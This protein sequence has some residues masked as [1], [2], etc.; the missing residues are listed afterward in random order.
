MRA[1]LWMLLLA[2][3]G[4]GAADFRSVGEPG[5]I[6]YDA[7]AVKGKKLFV[8]S[9]DYPVEV[10]LTNDAWAR[11]RDASG[12]LAWVERKALSERRTVVVTAPVA[13][14]RNGPTDQS[15]VA[16]RVEKGVALELLEGA[17][18][19]WARVRLRDGRSGF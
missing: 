1:L 6:F 17:T 9:R 8:V 13:D 12:E 16:F 2:S 14:V 7:P 15:A 19:P 4:A 11:V 18:G 10:L 3:A 5:T